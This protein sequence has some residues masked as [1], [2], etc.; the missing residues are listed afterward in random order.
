MNKL[1]V[2]LFFVFITNLYSQDLNL[3]IDL[4]KKGDFSGLVKQG[5][6]GLIIYSYA[7]N[8]KL[9][10]DEEKSVIYKLNNK[11]EIEWENSIDQ[12]LNDIYLANQNTPFVYHIFIED[13]YYNKKEIKN[14]SIT[15]FDRNGKK[16]TINTSINIGLK[17]V[18][19]IYGFLDNES[20]N[21]IATTPIELDNKDKIIKKEKMYVFKMKHTEKKFE[22]NE[23]NISSNE[24]GQLNIIGYNKDNIIV[25][26]TIRNKTGKLG[27]E[28]FVL[29]K[30]FNEINKFEIKQNTKKFYSPIDADIQWD[31]NGDFI[32]PLKFDV[33]SSNGASGVQVYPNALIMLS[34]NEKENRILLFGMTSSK[35]EQTDLM[36]NP[37][38]TI[39]IESFDLFGNNTLKTEIDISKQENKNAVLSKIFQ[40]NMKEI[41]FSNLGNNVF[42]VDAHHYLG[43]TTSLILKGNKVVD[44]K[45]Y[46][47]LFKNFKDQDFRCSLSDDLKLFLL[48]FNEYGLKSY[49]NEIE[50][51]ENFNSS[52]AYYMAIELN[53]KVVLLKCNNNKKTSIL[54]IVLF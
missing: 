23:L 4:G 45:M 25:S 10:N 35:N 37:I 5:D 32:S 7:P 14:F 6:S 9:T 13:L 22:K 39:V 15:R 42:R 33:S 47:N 30:K 52:E 38:Q 31:N 54:Q 19:F 34:Y 40:G 8:N 53:N 49:I 41:L 50:N 43:E 29:D 11:L 44:S 48:T 21:I 51:V 17:E 24:E 46:D 16:T 18:N 36:C 27:V 2:L 1:I 28:V 3:E 26:N 20:L 12:K